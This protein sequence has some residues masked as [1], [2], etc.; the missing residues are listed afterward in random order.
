MNTGAVTKRYAKALLLLTRESGRGE[1][2]CAQ[3]IDILRDPA[4]IPSPLEEDLGKFISFLASK[5]RA[6]YLRRILR[7]FVDL[8]CES[9]GLQHAVLTSAVESPELEKK[10]RG[11]LESR[12]GGK[13]LLE[14][15]VDPNLIGGYRL[16]V[17]GYMM[18]GSVRRQL[19]ILRREF[20]VR[21]NRIV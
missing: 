3:V 14:T 19:D 21:N 9:S 7:S 18:D 8:Y 20:I 16:E 17:G 15:A 1:Q 13:V 10:V 12:F 11:E 6:D 4:N 5:G 2:V